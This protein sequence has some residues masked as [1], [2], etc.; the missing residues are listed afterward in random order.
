MDLH[1]E[2]TVI[3]T[4]VRFTHQSDPGGDMTW[5]ADQIRSRTLNTLQES[6]P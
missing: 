2:A 3:V 5:S 4:N 1:A 6:A